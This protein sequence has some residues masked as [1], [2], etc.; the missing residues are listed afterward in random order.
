[1]SSITDTTPYLTLMK[2]HMA[3][4]AI[5]LRANQILRQHGLTIQ[6]ALIL[7]YLFRYSNQKINQK[8]IEVFMGISNPSVTSLM[9]TMVSKKLI[10]RL[11]DRKDARSYLLGLTEHGEQLYT[12]V[13]QSL[14]IVLRELQTGLD[15]AEMKQLICLLDKLTT[16]LNSSMH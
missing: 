6:Q 5:Y 16:N 9:K 3:D 7:H 10:R 15:E 12:T 1:M 4:H 13:S 14:E 11:P 8:D 2:L